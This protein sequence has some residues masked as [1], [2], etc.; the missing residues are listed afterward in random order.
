M[1]KTAYLVYNTQLKRKSLKVKS[2]SSWQ[3]YPLNRR[4]SLLTS[5]FRCRPREIKLCVWTAK[6]LLTLVARIMFA[7]I[8]ADV[9]AIYAHFHRV[10]LFLQLHQCLARWLSLLPT[11]FT[12]TSENVSQK[13][14]YYG[15]RRVLFKD[16][17]SQ[18]FL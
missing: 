6:I 15:G 17:R 3:S 9:D 12:G 14:K 16:I 13:T 4:C 7:T 8:V 1:I 11:T 10:L 2:I 18:D 5:C